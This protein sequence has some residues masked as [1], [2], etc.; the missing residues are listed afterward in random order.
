MKLF[1]EDTHPE[2]E[3]ILLEAY[4]KMSPAEKWKRVNELTISVQQLA[5]ARIKKQYGDISERE[6][7]LR[8]A[9]LW[10]DRDLMIDAFGWDP[11]IEGY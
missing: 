2:I 4:R 11:E 10:I 5:L 3:E 8:L 6:Q 9:A 7:K 1:G